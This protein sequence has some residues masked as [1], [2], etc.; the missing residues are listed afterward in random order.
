[1]SR[2]GCGDG[3]SLCNCGVN[4]RSASCPRVLTF[5]A[6]LLDQYIAYA[7]GHPH[8]ERREETIWHVFEAESPALV[9]SS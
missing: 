4:L 5:E 9:P 2:A 1:M 6:R 8:P 7:K 3:A